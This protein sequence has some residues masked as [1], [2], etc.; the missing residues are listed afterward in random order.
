M[1]LSLFKSIVSIEKIYNSTDKSTNILYSQSNELD[2]L[3][4]I[5]ILISKNLSID[6]VH[7]I[8]YFIKQKP[9]L[10]KSI[11]KNAYDYFP[12][13][14]GQINVLLSE[15]NLTWLNYYINDMLFD[16][17]N[18]LLNMFIDLIADNRSYFVN[19]L[20]DIIQNYHAFRTYEFIFPRL[21]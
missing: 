11:I 10:A 16:K 1:I 13:Y 18:N 8:I 9:D 20:I 7:C 4:C 2:D 6:F 17:T 19:I 21:K 15:H 3:K 14:L 12:E 5:G